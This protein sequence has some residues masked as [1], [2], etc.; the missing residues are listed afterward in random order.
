[1]KKRGQI[2]IFIVLGIIVIISTILLLI[3]SSNKSVPGVETSPLK[4]ESVKLFVDSCLKKTVQAGVIKIGENGGYYHFNENISNFHL[5]PYYFYENQTIVPPLELIENELESY[6]KNR[7]PYCTN[8]FKSFPQFDV[9]INP[10]N[11]KAEILP[12]QI[13]VNLN[14]P[15]EISQN[16]KISMISEFEYKLDCRL[17]TTHQFLIDYF[18]EWQIK[19]PEGI[20]LSPFDKFSEDGFYYYFVDTYAPDFT[21]ILVDNEVE[22]NNLPFYYE[23]ALRYQLEEVE[24]WE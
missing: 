11:V 15:L 24:P 13:I 7:L 19:S 22:V 3:F 20:V 6:V 18:N 12:T 14:Y 2:T 10:I 17:G 1:M 8:W 16:D 5:K 4:T 9:K 21:F 23:F